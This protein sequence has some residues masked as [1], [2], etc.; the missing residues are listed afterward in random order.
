MRKKFIATVIAVITAAT[1]LTAPEV[2]ACT[3]IVYQGADSLIAVG[4]SLD[5]KTPIPTNL[6]V[7]PR[8]IKKVSHNLPG[9]ISWTS[10]YGS[11]YAVGYD[12]G[13]TE[14]MNEMGLTVN[15]LFCKGTV[16]VGEDGPGDRAPMSLAVFVTWLLDLNATT[17]E[18]V[19]ALRT[20]PFAISG[21]S[22]D[23]GTSTTLHWAI[24]DV[25]GHTAVVEFVRGEMKIYDNVDTPVLTNDPTWPAMNAINDYWRGVGGVNMLPGTVKSP[26][27]FVRA[28]FFVS[29]VSRTADPDLAVAITRS[30]VMNCSVPYTYEIETEPNVS[31]TQWRSIALPRDRRYYFDIV[32][33]PGMVYIDLEALDI[34]RGAP[35]LKLD[36]SMLDDAVGCVNSRLKASKPFTPVY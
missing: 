13:V 14:G 33:N 20:T 31:S 30:I 23:G 8:G 4:R 1:G 28:D 9:A 25:S 11:V 5:W 12:S 27:R 34:Y 22:F 32:T 3:R 26:D 24:T 18:A 6:W 10:R 2:G 7:Y 17:A 16:Y 29:H 36:T 21:S 15:G 19:N 35:I